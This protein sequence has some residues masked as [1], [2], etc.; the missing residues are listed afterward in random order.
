LS[1]F[2]LRS[3]TS[4]T[5]AILAT[6][7]VI[8]G[9]GSR[10]SSSDAPS[11][12]SAVLAEIDGRKI[13]AADVDARLAGVRRIGRPEGSAPIG[14][15][16]MLQQIIE[17]EILHR[18]AVDAGLDQ[19]AEVRE[20]L[21]DYERQ[22]LV[23]AYLDRKQE[24]ISRVSDE[25]ARAFYEAHRDE[26][27]TERTRR[28]R[29]LLTDNRRNAE[30]GRR[31]AVDNLLSF[32]QVCS[33]Y[34]THPQL[35]ESLGLIP[36]WVREGKAV[37]WIGNHP[38]FH[39]VVATLEPGDVSDVFEIPLGLIVVRV[40]EV[41]EPRQRPF[42]E[43]ERDVRG[44]LARERSAQGL[45]DLLTELRERYHVKTYEKPARSPDELFAEAQ[46]ATDPSERIRLYDELV[47]RYPGHELA[48]DSHFMIGFIRAE[49]LR[50]PEGAAASF[51]T[52]IELDPDSELANSARWMLSSEA[53]AVPEFQDSADGRSGEGSP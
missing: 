24:E 18:A 20:H 16:R 2:P 42:E 49:E 28:V 39:E 5:A 10:E 19:E 8:A 32:P 1:A 12:D 33:R 53:D 25:D 7:I 41:R 14:R 13:T 44:R 23:Q 9:C 26:Y 46:A 17:Q 36:G 29:M 35:V 45:P 37:E 31:L 43:V 51:E 38:K 11:D 6:F 3:R 21:R 27:T 22:F 4:C 15:D 34:S 48:L 50:D 30:H 52:V 47:T 40:E